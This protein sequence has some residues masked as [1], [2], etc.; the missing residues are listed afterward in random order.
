[1]T[2]PSRLAA[3]VLCLLVLSR[4]G[5]VEG[6]WIIA[7][8]IRN[9]S[10]GVGI[11]ALHEQPAE[12]RDRSESVAVRSRTYVFDNL[13]C[14]SDVE[15]APLGQCIADEF[16][17]SHDPGCT[18]PQSADATWK[19]SSPRSVGWAIV[20]FCRFPLINAEC[21]NECDVL[22]GDMTRNTWTFR[23]VHG[24]LD[25]DGILCR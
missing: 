13:Q 8:E 3:M 19:R 22:I 6:V 18:R 21:C 24:R 23:P 1:M 16:P 9:V 11:L 4:S 14:P 2:L 20:K 7:G 10:A 17:H 12:C 15:A 5:C 25:A